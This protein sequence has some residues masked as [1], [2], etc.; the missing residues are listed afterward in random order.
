MPAFT[1]FSQR[2]R[3]KTEN[4]WL[5]RINNQPPVINIVLGWDLLTNHW[6]TSRSVFKITQQLTRSGWTSRPSC[7]SRRHSRVHSDTRKSHGRE[8]RHVGKVAD[9]V[10]KTTCATSLT[11]NK[12]ETVCGPVCARATRERTGVVMCRFQQLR[13]TQSARWYSLA[14]FNLLTAGETRPTASDPFICSTLSL[15]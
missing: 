5:F 9:F 1:A 10:Q 2:N 14:G 3:A 8:I 7:T 4:S 6:L 12:A 13:S 15:S 11:L